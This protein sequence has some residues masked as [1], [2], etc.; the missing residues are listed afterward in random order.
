MLAKRTARRPWGPWSAGRGWVPGAGEVDPRPIRRSTVGDR[1]ASRA[2]VDDG[3]VM[4]DDGTAPP[5][6]DERPA[7]HGQRE[8]GNDPAIEQ[9]ELRWP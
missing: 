4:R 8:R 1:Q 7:P 9:E 2:R 3:E 6:G 5:R